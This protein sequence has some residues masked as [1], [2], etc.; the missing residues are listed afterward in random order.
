MVRTA[1]KTKSR[2]AAKRVTP[3]RRLAPTR[4][5]V[6]RPASAGPNY[7]KLAIGAKLPGGIF[8]GITYRDSKPHALVLGPEFDGYPEDWNAFDAWLKTLNVDGCTDFVAG[9]QL[10]GMLLYTNLRDHFKREAYWLEQHADS[11]SYAWGRDFDNGTQGYW[12]KDFKLR[13]RAVRRIPI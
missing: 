3:I 1:S 10:D 7:L 9:S 8:A 2:A 11:P 5:A 12:Y 13:A 4:R 6:S